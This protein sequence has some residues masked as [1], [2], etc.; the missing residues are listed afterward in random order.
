[1]RILFVINLLIQ[2]APKQVIAL[3]RELARARTP[4]AVYTLCRTIRAPTSWHGSPVK[5]IAGSEERKFDP[6]LVSDI[7][8]EPLREF[9]ADIVHGFLLEGNPYARLAAAS[10]AIPVLTRNG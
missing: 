2:A 5:I 10:T 1:M 6:A 8:A 4:V 3:S 7:C 9:K